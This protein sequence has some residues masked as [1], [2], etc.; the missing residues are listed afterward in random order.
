MTNFSAEDENDAVIDDE[1][2]DSSA[3]ESPYFMDGEMANTT[4]GRGKKKMN[5][6]KVKIVLIC[7]YN[8]RY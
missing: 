6:K 7:P 2:A 5:F 4:G 8:I 3:S 1:C